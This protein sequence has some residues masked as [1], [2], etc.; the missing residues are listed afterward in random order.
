M[1]LGSAQRDVRD[2]HEKFGLTVN[3]VP[4]FPSAEVEDL[5]AELVREEAA[6]LI[7]AIKA[8]SIAEIAKEAADVLYVVLGA[9]VSYGIE[10]EPVWKAVH[11]SNMQKVGGLK[12]AT[13]K[14]LKPE[15]W[16]KPDILSLINAQSVK[17]PSQNS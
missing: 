16:K 3:D 9:M 1:S 12:S 7:E 8:G 14:I 5:R 15:G 13:G 6:E 2:F 17:S 10:L 4:S 11:E